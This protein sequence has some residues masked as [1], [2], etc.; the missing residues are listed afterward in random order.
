MAAAAAIISMPEVL[1]CGEGDGRGALSHGRPHWIC[2][3]SR[4]ARRSTHH[5]AL[6]EGTAAGQMRDQRADVV[7]RRGGHLAA[8]RGSSTA[9]GPDGGVAGTRTALWIHDIGLQICGDAYVDWK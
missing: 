4:R 7:R 5:V 8:L 3:Y 9:T 1:R 2:R 6:R